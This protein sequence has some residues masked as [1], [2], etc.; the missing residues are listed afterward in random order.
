MVLDLLSVVR[1]QPD[2]LAQTGWHVRTTV[3]EVEGNVT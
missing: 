2:L 3:Q 1:T